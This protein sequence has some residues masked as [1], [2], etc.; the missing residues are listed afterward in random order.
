MIWEVGEDLC[1][2]G[3]IQLFIALF[4]K[5]EY[6]WNLIRHPKDVLRAG[7]QWPNQ[8]NVIMALE[9]VRQGFAQQ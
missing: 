2:D 7:G 3:L 9:D 8:L 6:I 4:H 5:Q 1:R